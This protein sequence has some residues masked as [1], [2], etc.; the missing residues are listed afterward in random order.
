MVEGDRYWH[1]ISHLQ[2]ETSY[3][4]KMQCFNEGGESEFSNV[5]I[6]ETKA[7]KFSGQPGR[8]PP[9]TLAPPQP[10]PLE[11]MERPV[12]T[13]AMVAR[14]SDLPYL[15][16]GVV[17]GSI[18]LIIVTFI[19]F[20]LWRAWSKQKHTTDLGFPRSAL[21]SSSCQYTMV[22]LE[23]LPGHQAN[24]QPYL[25]GVSG[26]ACVSRVHGSRGCPAATVG[27]PGRKPQ[28]HCPGELAQRED[29]NSQLRQPIVS[30]GYDLQNQQ[31]AR[32]PQCASGVGAFLY[33]LPDDSTHQLLQP[34]DCCH[35]QKQPVTTCQTAVRRTSESPGL[36]SSWDP[37]YHSGPRCCLGLVPVEEVDSSDSCQVGGGDW[38]S[39]HPSGT[40]TG[41]ERGM[42]FSPSP[43]VHVSFETPPPTI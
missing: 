14:A 40:Y 12:G 1:S 29:T 3:D 8:P 34:Q 7:R 10:P 27:C 28:Q 18:V 41:Q 11:T 16:V 32:G 37:P 26:R 15:I 13:G 39:Q 17:L 38:S 4:I 25:G 21:L 22:P 31:V 6:C 36:E 19:P 42:R 23:G 33:T 2:P 43:S 9:L 30:N 24:G 20:C 35:L 5:M